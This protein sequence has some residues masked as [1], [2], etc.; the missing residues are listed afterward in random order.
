M[1]MT[2]ASLKL[3]TSLVLSTEKVIQ[4]ASGLSC[5]RGIYVT[6]PTLL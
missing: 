3:A 5:S 6:I 4:I 2:V 1:S